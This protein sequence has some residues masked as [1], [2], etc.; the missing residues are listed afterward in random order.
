MG[1]EGRR[2]G[3]GDEVDRAEGSNDS[4][5]GAGLSGC[6]LAYYE[7]KVIREIFMGM[8]RTSFGYSAPFND[9][10]TALFE[11]RDS[12]GKLL[13]DMDTFRPLSLTEFEES[14]VSLRQKIRASYP[15]SSIEEIQAHVVAMAEP[16]FQFTVKFTE[17]FRSE[18]VQTVILSHA[19]CEALINAIL[20]L[21][22]AQNGSEAV[23]NVL[24]RASVIDKWIVG[25]K[26]F[27]TSY[28]FPKGIELYA[29]LKSLCKIR[30]DLVHS[31][32]T[33][34]ADGQKIL[35]GTKLDALSFNDRKRATKF[36][37][38]PYDLLAFASDNLPKMRLFIFAFGMRKSQKDPIGGG[39]GPKGPNA[40]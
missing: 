12:F 17:K 1:F 36:L 8:G 34:H 18:Y 37:D 16:S 39:I 3:R 27:D 10:E 14:D 9:I 15:N 35:D 4:T 19:L 33:L 7:R 38:L 23:F 30:N 28:D 24:E 29:L 26:C 2:F 21:G 5:P 20:A 31:K 40:S 13:E 11:R 22:L 25:P 32:I 6:S